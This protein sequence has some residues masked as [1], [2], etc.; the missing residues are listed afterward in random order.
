MFIEKFNKNK[1]L[2]MK[3]LF[4]IWINIIF[5]WIVITEGEDT[6]NVFWN[7]KSVREKL[8]LF[9][10]KPKFFYRVISNVFPLPSVIT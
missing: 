8:G 1:I 10:K 6:K 2:E 7:Q 9:L 3:M 5:I 4:E